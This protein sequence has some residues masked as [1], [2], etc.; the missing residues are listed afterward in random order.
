MVEDAK[1]VAAAEP[2]TLAEAIKYYS[3]IDVATKTFSTL[4]WPDGVTCPYC[5]SKENYYAPSRRIWKCK[6]CRKQFSPKVGTICEDS[7]I[8]LGKWLT[9]IWMIAS[10]K[11]GI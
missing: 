1:P 4:R 8:G 6:A 11:N 3:D 7:A 5:G 9:A 10:A 2:Q